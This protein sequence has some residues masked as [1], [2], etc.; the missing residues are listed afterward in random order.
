MIV[1]TRRMK[2][3]SCTGIINDIIIEPWRLYFYLYHLS[4]YLYLY[5]LS[6]L[7]LF[8]IVVYLYLVVHGM[9]MLRVRVGER[10]DGCKVIEKV[11]RCR[12]V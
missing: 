6:S 5:S 2:C 11:N 12:V 9:V 4:L 7:S 8:S 1:G 3:I 10:V